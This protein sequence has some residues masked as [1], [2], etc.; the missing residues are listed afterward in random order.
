[1]QPVTIEKLSYLLGKA[2]AVFGDRAISE[3]TSHEIAA[4]RMT[5]SPGY[6]FN[7][8]KVGVD[9]PVRR[10]KE[11]HPFESWAELD[12]IGSPYGPTTRTVD[13][14]LTIAR[15]RNPPVC[16]RLETCQPS[17]REARS[18][19]LTSSVRARARLKRRLPIV[20]VS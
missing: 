15:A 19:R 4:W 3:L 11:Q 1:V 5:L 13:S 20:A 14:L 17:M 18:L 10:R 12:A 16:A 6:H 8:A 7:P 9:N 2:T